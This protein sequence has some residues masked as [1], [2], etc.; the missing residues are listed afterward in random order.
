MIVDLPR[1]VRL[2]SSAAVLLLAALLPFGAPP[3]SAAEERVVPAVESRLYFGMHSPDGSGVSEQEW[4]DFL[5][6]VVTPRF[7]GGLTVIPVYG[8]SGGAT[9]PAVI[10]ERTKLLIVVHPDT[11]ED[12]AKMAE[13]KS[14]YLERF[15][16]TGVFHTRAPVGIVLPPAAGN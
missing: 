5:A 13:I 15:A 1:P 12:N 2:R 7:P 3:A 11:P 10:E 9:P 4:R 16:H 8:Q 6:T 14:I